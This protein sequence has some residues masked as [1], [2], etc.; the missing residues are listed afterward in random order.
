MF[1]GFC[2]DVRFARLVGC[3]QSDDCEGGE[4]AVGEGQEEGEEGNVN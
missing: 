4:E 3:W 1:D 2:S